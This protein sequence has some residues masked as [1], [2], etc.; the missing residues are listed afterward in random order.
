MY[1]DVIVG[2]IIV[3]SIIFGLKNGFVVE[4]ISTFGVIINFVITQ[5]VTP[6]VLK[7]V[8]K[9]FGSN[10]TY[11]YV[12]TFVLVFI[13]FSVLIHILNLI[14]KK[15]SVSFISRILGG[16][17]SLVKGFIISALIL[18]IFNVTVDTF[19]KI[20]D[21]GKGSYAN[22]YF[23]EASKDADQ[24]IPEFFKEKLQSIRDNKT[25]DKYI[26]KLF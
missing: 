2:I 10:Y 9:Y 5:K 14:L 24:Y 25:I 23:L 20:E 15:Q 6:M 7:Y 3:I 12:I 11:T 8:E 13:I 17:L 16:I 22:S 18:L 19:P 26:D 21:Y 1:L 4:F